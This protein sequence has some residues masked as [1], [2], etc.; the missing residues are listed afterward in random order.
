MAQKALLKEYISKHLGSMLMAVSAIP[1]ACPLPGQYF[2]SVT[3]LCACILT[4]YPLQ[5][6]PGQSF[7]HFFLCI[8]LELPQK[9]PK[10][11]YVS[12]D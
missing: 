7:S 12:E 9:N 1:G 8:Q 3:Q 4:W 6:H 11:L 10:D 2:L 5:L